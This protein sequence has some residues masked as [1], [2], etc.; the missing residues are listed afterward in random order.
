MLLSGK[1]WHWACAFRLRFAMRNCIWLLY[2]I[3]HADTSD[4]IFM[5][6]QRPWF[7]RW[8]SATI[9]SH[10]LVWGCARFGRVCGY[11]MYYI[12]PECVGKYVGICLSAIRLTALR[13]PKQGLQAVYHIHIHL[14]SA[15]EWEAHIRNTTP[16]RLC[17]TRLHKHKQTRIKLRTSYTL[18][19]RPLNSP[20]ENSVWFACALCSCCRVH[21]HFT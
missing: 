20:I 8:V 9:K 19:C 14:G 17:G 1:A 21:T 13:Q 18:L 16:K 6:I 3:K 15:N 11:Y 4:L 10:F 12:V 2:R 7:S 5:C